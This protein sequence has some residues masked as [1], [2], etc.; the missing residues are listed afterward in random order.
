MRKIMLFFLPV[1]VV[2]AAVG[3]G[4]GT[5]YFT[6]NISSSDS[7]NPTV[8]VE[9]LSQCGIINI[10]N[11]DRIYIIATQR[12]IQL[13][14]QIEVEFE[15]I[16]EL[17]PADKIEDKINFTYN[18]YI[19]FDLHTYI[20]VHSSFLGH[21]PVKVTLDTGKFMK[22][23]G[24][25]LPSLDNV[26]N[27]PKLSATATNT[28]YKFTTDLYFSYQEGMKPKTEEEVMNI[29]KSFKDKKITAEFIAE[30]KNSIA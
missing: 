15:L 11:K 8:E 22:Y 10:P 26:L 13:N 29:I 20:D 3:I 4:Y 1:L 2:L 14:Q 30:R 28:K 23:S 12:G 25:W 18:L 6:D 27:E 5:W 7:T 9:G 16:A 19:P 17:G 21:I 24:S